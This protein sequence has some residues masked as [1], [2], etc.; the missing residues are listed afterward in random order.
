MNQTSLSSSDCSSDGI[1]SISYSRNTYFQTEDPATITISACNAIV[2][3]NTSL[4]GDIGNYTVEPRN[5]DTFGTRPK[6]NLYKLLVCPH[7]R[8]SSKCGHLGNRPKCPI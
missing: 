6:S 2:C 1:C 7:F 8:G 5:V 3:R 4:S